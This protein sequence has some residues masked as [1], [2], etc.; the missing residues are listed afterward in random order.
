MRQRRNRSRFTPT[1]TPHQQFGLP[2]EQLQHLA[3]QVA[4]VEG[5]AREMGAIEYGTFRY[6]AFLFENLDRGLR[7]PGLPMSFLLPVILT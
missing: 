4:V 6:P 2:I 1:Y 5:D 7:H 3:F